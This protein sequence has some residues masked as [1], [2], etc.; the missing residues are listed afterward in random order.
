MSTDATAMLVF[1][2]KLRKGNFTLD[3]SELDDEW[4]KL[5][6]PMQP[7]DDGKYQSPEWD[8]W[9]DAREEFEKNNPWNV[10]TELYCSG[11]EPR[12]IVSSPSI[13][14]TVDWDETAE[15]TP[16][17]LAKATDEHRAA[18]REYCD[19]FGIPWSEPKWYLM[20]RWF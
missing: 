10:K 8:A 3:H 13:S 19:R 4:E 12:Y 16:E 18:L 1:G 17:T 2:V 11:D 5:Y 15:I 20:A 7:P 14:I 9:R 6:G